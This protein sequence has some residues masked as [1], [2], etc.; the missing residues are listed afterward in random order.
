[1]FV[2][3]EAG[4][5]ATAVDV[6]GGR[7]DCVVVNSLA[8]VDCG[9]AARVVCT[10]MPTEGVIS[11]SVGTIMPPGNVAGGLTVCGVVIDGLGVCHKTKVKI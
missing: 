7:S 2:N 8:A 5:G 1:M 3:G 4:D 6:I 9:D 11:S 10:W